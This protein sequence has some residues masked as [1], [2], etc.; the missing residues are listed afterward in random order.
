[1]VVAPG[2]AR[3]RKVRLLVKVRRLA[4]PAQRRGVMEAVEV[5]LMPLRDRPRTGSTR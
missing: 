2:E 1:V 4:L 5:R 3:R